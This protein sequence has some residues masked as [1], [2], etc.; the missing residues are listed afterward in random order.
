MACS[1]DDNK[2][3]PCSDVY[4][5]GLVVTVRDGGNTIT[6]GVTV[7]ATDGDYIEEL[8][9]LA[10]THTFE[11]AY[12]RTGTYTITVTGEGYA[13][14]VSDPIVV[15]AD[16]CHVITQQLTVNLEPAQ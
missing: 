4:T 7:T 11:G 2:T 1:D 14:Y 8:D 15:A 16:E 9:P 10:N 12:E 5:P 6:N 3:Q 13:P